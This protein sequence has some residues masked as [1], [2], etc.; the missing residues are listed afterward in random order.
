MP[1]YTIDT[2]SPVLVTGATGY[3]AGWIVKGLLEAG[4]TVHA[5]VRN[6]DD[7]AKTAHL[8]RIAETATGELKFFAAD[9]LDEGSYDAAMAG[10][11]IVFH[12]ASPFTTS[13][14]DPQKDL[15]DPAVKG[16]RNVLGSVQR[17]ESVHRVVLTSS[18]AAIYTDSIETHDGPGGRLD[19]TVWN[20][21][22]SLQNQP[23]SYSK[24]LA[25]KAAWEM[26]E[27]QGRWRLV[28][29]NP[30]LILGPALQD[31]PTSESVNIVRQLGDGTMK[32]GAPRYAIGAVDVRDVAEAHIA[33]AYLPDAQGRHI[34]FAESTDFYEMGQMLQDRF[35]DSYPLPKR[36]MPK[37]LFWLLGPIAAG[38]SRS[39]VSRNVGHAFRADN[40]KGKRALGL[41]YMPVKQ[42][43]N[44]MFAQMIEGGIIERR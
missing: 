43:I 30:A 10:C 38:V 5:A 4:V 16:T 6:P 41:D 9:L 33:A 1:S 24:T 31:R 14:D 37:G 34:V 27:G 17:T 29:I 20:S 26:S 19:E 21:T 8:R 13:V 25:E 12:T 32:Q 35:G 42:S 40:S 39:T 44:D 36:P 3:L 28:A 23:Y 2:D 7:T 15:I 22:A 11:G 18:C